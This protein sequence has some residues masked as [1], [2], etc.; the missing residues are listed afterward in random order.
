MLDF[1]GGTV[2]HISAGFAALAAAIVVGPRSKGAGTLAPHNIPF[3]L[4]GTALLWFGW[5]GFN[6]GSNFAG[7]GIGTAAFVNTQISA[8]AAFL[9]WISLDAVLF[10][11][12]SAAVGG[13]TGAIVGLVS[14]TPGSGFV[15]PWAAIPFGVICAS[16]TACLPS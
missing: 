8:S 10:K 1:A 11:G 15:R 5:F 13:A 14:I 4:L 2:V 3:V 7:D 16:L 9:T 12:R 6:G